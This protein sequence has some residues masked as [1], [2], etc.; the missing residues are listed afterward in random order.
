MVRPLALV[1]APLVLLAGGCSA[2]LPKSEATTA[3]SWQSYSEAQK[4]FDEGQQALKDGDWEAYGRAQQDLED[5]LK[6]AEEAQ[7]KA[8]GAGSGGTEEEGDQSTD[9]G[10]GSG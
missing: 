5:A 7:S 2:L 10:S 4:A 1:I 8:D 3:S 9:E 6:R